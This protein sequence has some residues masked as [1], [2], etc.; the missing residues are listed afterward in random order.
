MPPRQ[1]F[2]GWLLL[3]LIA[4]PGIEAAW[5]S[6][7]S[8][9]G[10]LATA[11]II[12]ML[13][14]GALALLRRRLPL[15]LLGGLV[16]ALELCWA[17][18][19]L[20]LRRPV[21]IDELLPQALV[22]AFSPAQLA[23]SLLV[24]AC[25]LLISVL[26]A[27]HVELPALRSLWWV[28]LLL[29]LAFSAN[30]YVPQPS[31][32]GQSQRVSPSYPSPSLIAQPLPADNNLSIKGEESVFLVH[33]GAWNSQAVNGRYEPEEGIVEP[34]PTPVFL[35][36]A[37]RGIYFPEFYANSVVPQLAREAVLCGVADN[38]GT[39]LVSRQQELAYACLPSVY[40][41]QGY[42]TYYFALAP[43]GQE[44][45]LLKLLGF[46]S[47]IT[48][49]TALAWMGKNGTALTDDLFYDF[50]F[51]YLEQQ[52]PGKKF[53]YI[54]A[55]GLHAWPF[56]RSNPLNL[57]LPYRTPGT[58]YERYA[59][60]LF[61]QDAALQSLFRGV[62][63]LP[64]RPHLF[65]FGGRS[66]PLGEESRYLLSD[67]TDDAFLTTL[68]YLSPDGRAPSASGRRYDQAALFWTVLSL[69]TGEQR[70]E[71]IPEIFAD[72]ARNAGTQGPAR[73][74]RLNQPIGDKRIIFVQYPKKWSYNPVSG[75]L[76]EYDLL[77]DPLEA[78]P[79]LLAADAS[80]A[81]Y[82]D[83]VR[84]GS[85][86][87]A[88]RPSEQILFPARIGPKPLGDAGKG[89]RT[90]MGEDFEY[91]FTVPSPREDAVAQL[92]LASSSDGHLIFVNGNLLNSTLCRSDT[93]P[94]VCSLPIPA[95]A[96]RPGENSLL[97][98][99][100]MSSKE[101]GKDDY[102]IYDLRISDS[103]RS[104]AVELSPTTIP[105]RMSS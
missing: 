42:A 66:W 78:Q 105:W 22:P 31:S 13:N 101:M 100:V 21:M 11:A 54:E 76:L 74:L 60:S 79:R 87:F 92:R 67:S 7:Q 38:A 45:E 26:A 40:A 24:V 28:P 49:E 90:P 72:D 93:T 102:M 32:L 8:F 55:S 15:R 91:Q 35:S 16:K 39:P 77:A 36:H 53:V 58:F 59:N 29:L 51:E 25:V 95:Q 4:L 9:G 85:V 71:S 27:R 63:G 2:H 104:Y 19:T 34:S 30:L 73:L 88:Q 68:L 1:A 65:L 3:L 103:S 94:I 69:G 14:A 6:T 18:L 48:E 37:A 50:V 96:L 12:V 80:L 5:F 99:G 83:F 47:V 86:T 46:E 61:Q 20:Q 62:A 70:S 44:S 56:L 10:W 57:T 43:R 75:V 82:L 81:E 97:I 89:Y 98:L 41:Q 64:A 52:P 84:G 33:L 17:V 23:I